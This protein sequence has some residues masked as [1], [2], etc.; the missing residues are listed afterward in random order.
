MYICD[1]C[2]D[3][4]NDIIAEECEQERPN[5]SG[6]QP[7]VLAAGIWC[8][9]CRLPKDLADV[10]TIADGR[11]VCRTCAGAIRVALDDDESPT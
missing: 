2:I 5:E 9:V 10:L 8:P 3:L 11:F 4:C 7:S 6:G 1:E